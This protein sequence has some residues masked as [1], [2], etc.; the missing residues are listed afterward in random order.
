MVVGVFVFIPCFRFIGAI[1]TSLK[2]REEASSPATYLPENP[3]LD[4]YRNIL[5]NTLFLRSIVNSILVAG[6]TTILSLAV[7]AFA[8]Y[9]LGRMRFRGRSSM[10]YIILAMNI[11]PTIA[12][13]PS[14]L[15][16]VTAWVCL[17]RCPL[18]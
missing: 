14:V 6:T 7:G 8:A 3:T 4:S 13:L 15:A 9:A 2:S 17:G 11:F 18:C 1:N 10:R 12:I 5:S 16:R